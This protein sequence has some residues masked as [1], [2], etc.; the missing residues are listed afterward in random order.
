M[1]YC[2]CGCPCGACNKRACRCGCH[3]K[4]DGIPTTAIHAALRSLGLDTPRGRNATYHVVKD[5]DKIAEVVT[6][7][8]RAV[9]KARIVKEARKARPSSTTLKRRLTQRPARCV[10]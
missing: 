6:A 2:D 10:E 8:K 4:L 1:L 5:S 3:A 7:A 9:V